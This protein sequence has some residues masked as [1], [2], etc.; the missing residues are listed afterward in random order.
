V[1]EGR[2]RRRPEE[3]R[4]VSTQVWTRVIRVKGEGV[5]VSVGAETRGT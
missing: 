5:R 4:Q 1:E 3:N 2:R